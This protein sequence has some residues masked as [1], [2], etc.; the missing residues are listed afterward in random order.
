M[1]GF[2]YETGDPKNAKTYLMYV[3]RTRAKSLG[4]SFNGI[5]HH[6]IAGKMRDGL[7]QNLEAMRARLES[8]S[9]T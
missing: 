9:Q 3:H 4:G 6:I 1:D 8:E 7:Q 2:D 5:K